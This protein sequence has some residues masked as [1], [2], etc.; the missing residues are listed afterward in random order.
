[1]SFDTPAAQAADAPIEADAVANGYIGSATDATNAKNTL[2]GAAYI[3]SGGTTAT[4]SNANRGVPAGTTV[5]M[6]WMDTDGAV[7]PVYSTVTHDSVDVNGDGAKAGEYAF[8]LREGFTDVNGTVHTYR[9]VDGQ[10]YR[11]WID[12]FVDPQTGATV[13]PLR[14]SGGFF[15]GSFVNSVTGSNLGQFPL[16][17]T[18]MQKTALFL[19][20]HAEDYMTRPQS[21][22]IVDDKGPL[23]SPAV[24]TSASNTISGKVWLETGAGDRANS[25]TGPN[26]NANDP[27]AVD[28]QV[29]FSALTAEGV[30]AVNQQ[31]RNLPEDEQ[32]AATRDLLEQHPEYISAT[33]VGRTDQDGKYT[34]RFPDGA[35]ANDNYIYGFV[36]DPNGEIQSAYSGYTAQLFQSPNNEVSLTPQTAPA[37]NLVVRPMWYNVNFAVVPRSDV[38]IDITN[39]DIFES[40]WKPTKPAAEV[41]LTGS[42]LPP[43]NN[44]VAWL[45]NGKPLNDA[46]G[47]PITYEISSLKDVQ[48]LD[49]QALFDAGLVKDGDV[50]TV[51][52]VSGGNVTSADSMIV[53]VAPVG[54]YEPTEALPGTNAE[55]APPT[56]TDETGKQ[57]DTPAGT[58]FSK[59]PDTPDG[60]TVNEDGSL[61]VPVS[62]DAQPGDEIDVPVTVSYEDGSTETLIAKVIVVADDDGDGALP[63]PDED[64]DGEADDPNAPAGNTQRITHGVRVDGT[65]VESN[66]DNTD[67]GAEL[68]EVIPGLEKVVVTLTNTETGEKFTSG[69]ASTWRGTSGYPVVQ[70]FGLADVPAGTYTVDVQG[71]DALEGYVI[72]TRTYA[73]QALS[74]GATVEVTGNTANMFVNL[75]KVIDPVPAYAETIA[76]AGKTTSV[77]PTNSG[78]DY[79]EGTVFEIDPTWTAPDG[80]TVEIDPATGKI[81]VTVAPMG[82]NGADV[83]RLEIP[84]IANY[85]DGS[86]AADDKVTA[87]FLLDTDSDGTPD[88]TD[89]DDDGDGIDDAV[90]EEKG[91]DPKNPGSIPATPIEPGIPT[92]SD[93]DGLTDDEEKEIGTDPN[94]PDTDGDGVNDGDE[95]DGSTNEDWDGDGKPDP[96]DPTN[97]DSDGDGINDGDEIKDGTDPNN[98]DTDGDGLTDGEEK[99]HG[100]DPKNPD[101]DGDGVNDGDEVNGGDHN[102]FDNDGDGKGDPTDPLNPDTDGD[103]VTD[104]E[105]TNTIVDEDGKTVP[106][107][108]ATDDKTDPNNPPADEEPE[109]PSKPITDENDP[110]Y[111]GG[112]GDPGTDVK[113]PA[114]TFDD[115]TTTERESDPAPEG[116]TFKPGDGA[117]EGTVIHEDGSITVTIPEDAKPGDVINVPVE[118][119]YPDGSADTV[120]VPVTVTQPDP[121]VGPIDDQT[122]V[123]GDPIAP[124]QVDAENG[125][126]TVDGLPEGVTYDPESGTI[127]GTPTTPGAYDV[128]VT[129]TNPDGETV[130]E[131][132]Q[133]VVTDPK[134]PA[135]WHDTTTPADTPVELPNTGGDVPEGST[136]ETEGPGTATIDPETGV[137]TVTPGEGAKPGDTIVVTVTDPE[138]NV[139]DKVTVTIEEP[140]A[141]KPDWS[142]TTTPVDTPVEIPNEGGEVPEGSTVET[143]GPGTATIDPETGVITV[144]PGEGAKPGDVIRVDVKDPEGSIIDV[145]SV[146]LTEGSDTDTPAE[147][148]DWS[149]TTTPV[150][151]PVEIPNEGGEVPEG[152]TVETEGP[153]TAT[154]DPETGVITVTPGEGAKPGDVI[155]VDVKDPEGN[156]IDV[157]SVE[158][159][160]GSDTDTPAEKPDWEDTTTTPG[161]DVTI[162]NTGGDVPEGSTVET[163]GPGKADLQDDGS[164]VVTPSPEAK[165]GDEIVVTV[166]D[167]EGKVIDTAVVKIVEPEAPAD[168]A[169]ADP[170]DPAPADPAPAD[171]ADP[172]PAD[173]APSRGPLARTGTEAAGIGTAAAALLAAGIALVTRRR[174]GKHEG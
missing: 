60:V 33:V 27:Q 140:Q 168:P 2:S 93:G 100:T 162:P 56:F 35:I 130:T 75:R 48:P 154:I 59:S 141:E 41:S 159:T 160:E 30:Q 65:I 36:M 146:E 114:P 22:W 170:A 94:N 76:P 69:D 118:V 134:T 161:K 32:V 42:Y 129:V 115:P 84:V 16:I 137:I 18:N 127:D 58:T 113:V 54:A 164:I 63:D 147:K 142:N 116:T 5:Y 77:T 74:D 20:S 40:P 6:Q 91:S 4:F 39:Y 17:G 49:V 47:N 89:N 96:T 71:E 156:I 86:T 158:L 131:E 149:N 90:E 143:E 78:D 9:A 138:G 8:D 105:E 15:P 50:L 132:F 119:T 171:P 121:T 106:D 148:P 123:V 117:P 120:D 66:G 126:V 68:T 153:G 157:I 46:N 144:T 128:V 169:P 61:V 174:K 28:Y 88:E 53:K 43:F 13:E 107:P 24:D 11:L 80:Y 73:G 92:D 70:N 103:G 37:Q 150:D 99:D 122:V 64:G 79:P 45:V 139:I 101:T 57:V 136:V 3:L 112:H 67:G 102:D 12:P 85:P 152:S 25:A 97:P 167:P 125:D 26:D 124:V 38:A 165:P 108:D 111:T 44:E 173:P 34:L 135:D 10:Y 82:P 155:R 87:V 72:D 51:Q 21:E 133:I 31:V 7:S 29:V 55:V 62:E 14:Q 151:T 52:L 166:K 1:M 145:I 172:A 163:E 81:S 19:G 104:G 110:V 95:V 109:E 98:P 23:K 83:E